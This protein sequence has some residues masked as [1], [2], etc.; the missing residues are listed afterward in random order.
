LKLKYDKLLSSFAF[1]FKLRHYNEES[2]ERLLRLLGAELGNF[3]DVNV[4]TTFTKL[5]KL[6]GS[7]SFPRNIAADDRFRGL[8]ALARD[9]CADGRLP[10]RQL[11]NILHAVAKMSAAGKLAT[12]DAD[13]RE[14][15]VGRCRLTVSKPELKARLVSA[16]QTKM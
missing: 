2:P 7:M 6:C 9:M 11:S 3:D 14:T 12:N 8:M 1:K 15:L 4:A 16:L 13:V 5:S 10:A